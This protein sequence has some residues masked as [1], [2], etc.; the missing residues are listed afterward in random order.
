MAADPDLLL[1]AGMLCGAL[2]LTALM[3]GFVEARIAPRGVL[4]LVMAAGLVGAAQLLEPGG[5]AL[6]DVPD[7]VIRVVG[8]L[9][10][11]FY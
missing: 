10:Q 5:Y 2:S 7:A 8:R 9:V 3:A 11:F 1:L 4:L 6:A